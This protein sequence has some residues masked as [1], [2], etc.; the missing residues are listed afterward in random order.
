MSKSI[1]VIDTPKNCRECLLKYDSYGEY[2]ICAASTCAPQ[3]AIIDDDN[4]KLSYCPLRPLPEKV[5][6]VETYRVHDY[7]YLSG[8]REGWNNCINKITGGTQ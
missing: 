1:L 4:T 2:D 7:D 3:D 8:Y 6:K 5:D